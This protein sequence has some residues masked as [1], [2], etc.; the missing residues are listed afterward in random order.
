MLRWIVLVL[1]A[2]GAACT[3]APPYHELPMQRASVSGA[4]PRLL[5]DMVSIDSPFA[6]RHILS[7]VLG[8][9]VGSQW[10]WA[11]QRAELRFQVMETE[12]RKFFVKFVIADSTFKSTGPV[13]MRFFIK[14]K[15]VG[16]MRCENHGARLFE[17]PVPEGLIQPGE[18]V[19]TSVEADK[20]WISTDNTKLGFLLV[21]AGFKD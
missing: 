10:R 8:G 11:N 15:L 3:S 12:R 16:T 18:I 9:P 7:G 21:S 2:L 19:Q 6:E 4:E 14:N 5:G 17:A 20:V 1:A 13:T